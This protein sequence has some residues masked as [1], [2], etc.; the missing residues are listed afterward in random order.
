MSYI[1]IN[2]DG[3]YVDIHG[4]SN[5]YIYDNGD[6]ISGWSY[7]EFAAL[8]G[9]VIREIDHQSSQEIEKSFTEHFGGWDETYDG[10]IPQPERA[11]IFCQCV[12]SRISNCTLTD[13]L[14][15]SV[16]EW[17][18]QADIIKECKYCDEEFRP[19]I[20]DGP[21]ICNKDECNLRADADTY[22]ITPEQMKE[23]KSKESFDEQWEYI[24]QHTDRDD[25]E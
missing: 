7:A 17:V 13:S 25:L 24:L 15:E 9:S 4:G 2:Q 22:E 11:E 10:G 8:I 19:R 23:A 5:C 18:D 14:H 20:Y 1:R 12:N 6:N 3:Q 21:Y 16:K